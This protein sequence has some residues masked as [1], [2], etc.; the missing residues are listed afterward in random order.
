MASERLKTEVFTPIPKASVITATR[1]KTGF[2]LRTRRPKF[3]SCQNVR[4]LVG[5]SHSYLSA[6]SGSTFVARRAGN[7]QAKSAAASRN[8]GNAKNGGGF[9][10]VKPNKQP[11]QKRGKAK[12]AR[13]PTPI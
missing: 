1:A 9:V 8:T 13:I 6:T 2:F 7:Q 5:L 11:G 3:K 4:T 12:A 10:G